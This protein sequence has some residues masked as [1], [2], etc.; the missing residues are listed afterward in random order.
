VLSAEPL[1]YASSTTSTRVAEA[2]QDLP[3]RIVVTTR[4][5]SQL[6][7]SAYG[8]WAKNLRL[9]D[10]DIVVRRVLASLLANGH[11]SRFSW[12]LVGRIREVWRPSATDGW[13]EVLLE[14]TPDDDFQH[15]F[16]RALG[17]D[18]T[19]PPA[20]PRQNRSLPFGALVAWQAHLRSQTRYD[21]R[22][23]G[24]T[25][26][27]VAR[28]NESSVSA[29]RSR[30]AWSGDMASLIDA[31]FPLAE[32]T[33][34][35]VDQ[36]RRQLR[37]RVGAR[38]SFIESKPIDDAHSL[39][40]EA[41]YWARVIVRRRRVVRARIEVARRLGVRRGHHPDWDAFRHDNPANLMEFPGE[42]DA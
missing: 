35:N 14:A 27:E 3:V 9:P 4:P 26:T 18:E 12:M 29:P 20:M 8:E 36:A 5:L 30:L 6:V 1:S 23:D 15:N 40:D 37:D 39:D 33:G 34:W 16:W 19:V 32:S 11:A 10:P 22:V 41:R 17:I 13:H 25:I 38:A 31:A 2:L 42:A 21:H 7:L 24:G 28:F